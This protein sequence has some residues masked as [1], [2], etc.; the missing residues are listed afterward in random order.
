MTPRF[1]SLCK[2]S[3]KNESLD[4]IRDDAGDVFGS[5]KERDSYIR[6]FYSRIYTPDQGNIQLRDNCIEDFLGPEVVANNIV[7][8]SKLLLSERNYFDRDLTIQ[9]LDTAVNKMNLQSAGSLDGIPTKFL[10]K[11]WAYFRFPLTNY[12]NFSFETG[13]LTQSFNSAGIKLIPKKGDITN[14]K[15]GVLY[16]C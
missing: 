5:E 1:L 8:N 12:A 13:H 15:T 7:Q 14:I 3:K 6:S 16:L 10:K 2:S 4:T 11:F 9:E